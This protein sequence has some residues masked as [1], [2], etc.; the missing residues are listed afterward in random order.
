M[1]RKI[2]EGMLNAFDAILDR[3]ALERFSQNP[4]G[5]ARGVGSELADRKTEISN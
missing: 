2:A 4:P 1:Q 3:T 5:E